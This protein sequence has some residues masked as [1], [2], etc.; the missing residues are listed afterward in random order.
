MRKLQLTLLLTLLL[1]SSCRD[2]EW[3]E[4]Y[5]WDVS[6]IPGTKQTQLP[7][8][9]EKGTYGGT[10]R[11]TY[12]EDPKSFNPFSNLD[13]TYT[14]VTNLI[15]D[16]LFDYDQD[17]KE[18][19]G[20]IV[21]SY[22][23]TTDLE[24]DRMD[25]HCRLR[26]DIYWSDGVKMTA[27]DVVWYFENI[28][29]NKEIYPLGEQGLYITMPDGS[30]QKYT[31]EKTGEY[32]FCYHFPRIVSEPL[33]V[34]NTGTIVAKHIW[35]PVL[36]QGKK[37]VE[38][39]WG[40]TTPPEELVGNG[41]FL[42]D[43]LIP[44]ERIIFKRNPNYWKK[45]EWGQQLPY[46]DKII[47]TYTP[48]SNSDLLKF[49]KG[50]TDAYAL[51]GQDLP[52]LLP[53][54]GKGRFDI[55]NGGPAGGYTSLIFNHNPDTLPDWK[56]RLFTD[57]KFKQAISCLI[58]RQTI[59]NQTTNGLSQPQYNVIGENNRY[60]DPSTDTP[61][62]YN[63]EQAV[64]LLEEAGYIDRNGDGIR[65]DGQ[66]N[67]LSFSILTW[68][69]DP[70]TQDYLNIIVSDLQNVGIKA[71]LQTADYNV[72]AQKLINTYDWECYLAGMSMPTF[73]E[74]WYNIWLPGGNLHYWHPKQK[75]PTLEWEKKLDT[76]YSQLIYTYD[77]NEIK[78]NYSTFQK[79][80][81]DNLI[82]IPIFRRYSFLA[83]E[84]GWRNLN[85]SAHNSIGDNF[86]FVYRRDMQ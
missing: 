62:S 42:L 23:V 25:L 31:I 80:I 1:L 51:R 6:S 30:R 39:F 14:T 72:I 73:P 11:D 24:H 33:L 16:Y 17:T 15:L 9:W 57:I 40:I 32:E 71:L 8:K 74:Q 50:E 45:D 70:V 43:K 63:P 3:K 27:E 22:N 48:D 66:G 21:E 49:Q 28:E 65:E 56:F 54:S 35:E 44:G 55:W 67:P 61:Y 34:V 5:S 46:I 82:I 68:S 37:A 83:A 79:T 53:E 84:S 36:K 10:W 12:A 19:S 58:D 75:E 47:L 85:W 13:G 81:M 69:T 77:Q 52:T 59:I 18:W 60:Y 2:P 41:A 7:L 38:A 86:R 76:L 29:N 26:D 20:N 64:K 78:K 4:E